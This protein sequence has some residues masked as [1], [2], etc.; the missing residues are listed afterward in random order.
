MKVI[1]TDYTSNY[2]DKARQLDKSQ[3]AQLQVDLSISTLAN[4]DKVHEQLNQ[5]KQQNKVLFVYGGKSQ[6]LSM[7]NPSICFFSGYNN[8]LYYNGKVIGKSGCNIVGKTSGKRLLQPTASTKV[9]ASCGTITN[10]FTRQST[11]DCVTIYNNNYTASNVCWDCLQGLLSGGHVV[12]AYDG[13]DNYIYW[14]RGC[15]VVQIGDNWYT[16]DYAFKYFYYCTKCK[17]WHKDYPYTIKGKKVC[18]DC[19]NKMGWGF[20]SECG[21]F[22]KLNKKRLCKYCKP[23]TLAPINDYH[24]SKRDGVVKYWGSKTNNPKGKYIGF[25]L[26]LVGEYDGTQKALQQAFYKAYKNKHLTL[27]YD[28]SLDNMGCE[29][30]SQ[31]HTP[32]ALKKFI[33]SKQFGE[34]LKML[35]NCDYIDPTS[36]KAGLHI[37]ISRSATNKDGIAKL[38]YMISNN[39]HL[40][41]QLSR[42]DTDCMSYCELFEPMNKTE[43]KTMAK[44][45]CND[46]Y[47]TLNLQNKNTIEW[48]LWSTTDSPKEVWQCALLSY[49]LTRASKFINWQDCGNFSNWLKYLTIDSIN[50]INN[51][52]GWCKV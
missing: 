46:R 3:V 34:Q 45:F 5:E 1:F 18:F 25:E 40:F 42:R 22:H 48:R 38:L 49:E 28:G 4:F 19:A 31:P 15:N 44:S 47:V 6:L 21:E 13:N 52:K 39:G 51:N 26:E 12:K 41:A 2:E 32:Q 14:Q 20:C 11:R 10:D 36:T 24:T 23:Q 35:S 27:E 30:I 9:C 7:L 16:L 29:V 37:H 43:C 33:F 17:R 50:Y 8:L